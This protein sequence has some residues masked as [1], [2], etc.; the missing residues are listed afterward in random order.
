MTPRL[1]F[2]GCGGGVCKRAVP[3]AAARA[4]NG[5]AFRCVCEGLSAVDGQWDLS[6]SG[7]SYKESLVWHLYRAS[8][9]AS[10]TVKNYTP[11]VSTFEI[12][13]EVNGIEVQ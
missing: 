11:E 9:N 12:L 13:A 5:R 8:A 7:P 4:A 2:D 1:A 10:P 3:R 6:A